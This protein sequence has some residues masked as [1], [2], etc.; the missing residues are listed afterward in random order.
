MDDEVHS[1]PEPIDQPIDQGPPEMIRER[2][3]QKNCDYV[4]QLAHLAFES[5]NQHHVQAGVRF[6]F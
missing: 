2:S 4:V 3:N 1:A 6:H 5:G